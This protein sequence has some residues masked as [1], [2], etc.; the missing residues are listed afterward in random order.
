GNET[1]IVTV[2][3][4]PNTY[5]VGAPATATVTIA[6]A[7]APAVSVVATT[8]NASEV[9]PVNGVFTFTRSAGG[10]PAA[11]LLVLY[12][13]SGTAANNGDYLNINGAVTIQANQT[14]ATV[15]I[16]PFVDGAVEGN[17]TVIVTI[18]PNPNTYVVGAPASA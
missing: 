6:D 12:S 8:P 16:V 17:E 2:T 9:G 18:T 4:N 14:T 3:P 13:T 10:N 15:T 5:V 11:D 1:V 7:P